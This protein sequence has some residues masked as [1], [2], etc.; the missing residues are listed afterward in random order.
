[1]RSS[2]RYARHWMLDPRVVFLNH[3][4]FGACPADVLAFQ[5]ALRARM[6]AEPVDFLVRALPELAAEARAALAAFAG[7]DADD[8]AFLPNATTGVNLVL[9]S[10]ELAPGDELLTT[11]HA[12]AACAKALHF[13]AT[14]TGARVVVAKV[15]FPL[16]GDDAV[17]EPIVAA[18][19][20]RTKLALID[21]VT[22]PT[23]LVWPIARIVR[24]LDA[25]G[26]DTLVDGAHAPGMVPLAFDAAGAAY[27]VGNAHK[28]LCAPKGAAYLH[29]RHDRQAR[30]RPLVV[31]HGYDPEA[32]APRFR[33]ELDW[34]GTTDPT[35]WLAI[36][37]CLRFL[38]ELVPG[39]WDALRA[40]N[41][42]L[43]LEARA[44]LADALGVALPCPDAM[45]G[46][47]A[48][49]PLPAV[50]ARSPVAMLDRAALADFLR[51][52]GIETWFYPWDCAGGKLVRIS[53]QLYNDVSQYRLLA[54][55]LKEL[56][57]GR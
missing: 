39:G 22:S 29:V 21:H 13:V 52:R 2:S 12:Y 57:D 40:R 32:S 24:E 46:A 34:S 56:A 55:M 11:D 48:S 10:L 38:G 5:T 53:A 8:L 50:A 51:A 9:R 15:P 17:V 6:E 14:R 19:T 1:M 3:G 31:S 16:D 44:V 33:N 45:I 18:V 54:A 30:V 43:A 27:T 47:M 26:V 7:C 42:A 23:A 28:W 4:S 35:S 49:L 41:R 36:P 20:P 37:E 25:R